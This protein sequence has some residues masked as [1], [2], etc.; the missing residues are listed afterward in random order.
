MVKKNNYKEFT[1][2][3]ELVLYYQDMGLTNPKFYKW[4]IRCIYY[5]KEEYVRLADFVLNSKKFVDEDRPRIFSRA[6]KIK[7]DKHLSKSTLSKTT[8]Q[9]APKA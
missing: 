5:L 4:H 8:P 2:L 7:L 6:L 9:D 1:A 3:D